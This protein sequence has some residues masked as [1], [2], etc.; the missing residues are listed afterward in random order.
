[1]A[2]RYGYGY[3][4]ERTSWWAVPVTGGWRIMVGVHTRGTYEEGTRSPVITIE[5]AFAELRVIAGQRPR[6]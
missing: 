2:H 3:G 5:E 1:M 4:V 6:R